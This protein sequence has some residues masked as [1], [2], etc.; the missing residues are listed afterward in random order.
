MTSQYISDCDVKGSI[1]LTH[2]TLL[3]HTVERFPTLPVMREKNALTYKP[4]K[5]IFI[6]NSNDVF[7]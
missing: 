5:I 4:W 2:P 7:C 1:R 3:S 6:A